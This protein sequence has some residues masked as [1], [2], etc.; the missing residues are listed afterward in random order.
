MGNII[1]IE[2]TGSFNLVAFYRDATDLEVDVFHSMACYLIT[3][4][5]GHKSSDGHVFFSMFENI[6]KGGASDKVHKAIKS[7]IGHV[8]GVTLE[9]NA[10]RRLVTICSSPCNCRGSRSRYP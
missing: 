9:D 5:G 7:C 2:K 1:A 6:R 10:P 8:P 4:G 3:Q